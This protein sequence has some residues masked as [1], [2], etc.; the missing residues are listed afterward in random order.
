MEPD[1]AGVVVAA[2]E[3]VVEEWVGAGVEV[4]DK[5]MVYMTVFQSTLP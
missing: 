4:L 1:E 3:V 2:G 5:D